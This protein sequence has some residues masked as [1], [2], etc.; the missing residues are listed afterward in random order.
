MASIFRFDNELGAF[1]LAADDDGRLIQGDPLVSEMIL[2]LYTD[3]PADVG[4]PLPDGVEYRGNVA[5]D[6]DG[7]AVRGSKLW[8]LRYVKPL[9]KALEYAKIWAEDALQ[10]IV[11]RGDLLGVVASASLVGKTIKIRVTAT[12]P[13]GTARTFSLAGVAYTN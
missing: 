13:D 2:A 7:L 3:A 10:Y 9:A 4:D 8:I 12:L 6:F 1:E 5:A 11:D